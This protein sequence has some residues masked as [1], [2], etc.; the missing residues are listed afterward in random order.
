MPPQEVGE[1]GM[2]PDAA[3]TRC[4]DFRTP[5]ARHSD[6]AA[7]H[8]RIQ[9]LVVMSKSGVFTGSGIRRA[10]SSRSSAR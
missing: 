5:H 9:C 4:R 7:E 3:Q 2:L 8:P 10:C 1:S 6:L